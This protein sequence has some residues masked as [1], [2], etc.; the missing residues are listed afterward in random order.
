MTWA[1]R[2]R[3]IRSGAESRYPVLTELTSRLMSGNLLDACT[4]LA[5]QAFLP[6]VPLFFALAAFAP[7][8]VRDQ[9]HESL[10]AMFGLTGPSDQQLQQVLDRSASDESRETTGIVGPLV[11]LVSAT[12]FSRAMARVCERAWGLPKAI[13]RIAARRWAVW[14]PALFLVV[15]IQAPFR[16]GFG[17]DARL[18]VPVFFRSATVSDHPEC[19][20]SGRQSVRAGPPSFATQHEILRCWFGA[21]F[22]GSMG[23][24]QQVVALIR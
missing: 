4:R 2:L 11:A 16:D 1:D 22:G 24:K 10:R 21:D 3:G 7:L 14:L 15:L 17:A 19:L 12:R 9:L 23:Q 13:S 8:G 6:A 5:A 20:S 18:G